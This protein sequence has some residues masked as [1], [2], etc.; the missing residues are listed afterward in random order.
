MISSPQAVKE[1]RS[2]NQYETFIK[3]DGRFETL[4]LLFP[5]LMDDSALGQEIIFTSFIN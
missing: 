5:Q 4:L 2:D 3:I 1:F